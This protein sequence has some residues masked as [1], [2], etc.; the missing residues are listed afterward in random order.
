ML[1]MITDTL[2][3]LLQLSQALTCYTGKFAQSVVS[4]GAA[5]MS[6]C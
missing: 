3:H 2:V 4:V 5:E 1:K 6:L